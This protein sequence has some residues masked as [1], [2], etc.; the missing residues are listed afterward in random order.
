[1]KGCTIMAYENMDFFNNY[2]VTVEEMNGQL[3]KARPVF[4]IAPGNVEYANTL[5]VANNRG[6]ITLNRHTY[7]GEETIP[8]LIMNNPD[9]FVFV[10]EDGMEV[11][12]EDA[13]TVVDVEKRA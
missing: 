1:M 10:L 7:K 11:T 12:T 2:I 8:A 3:H 4:D 9:F 5:N 13:F 6:H